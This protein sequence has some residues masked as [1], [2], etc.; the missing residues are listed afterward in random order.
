MTSDYKEAMRSTTI[1]GGLKLITVVISVIKSKV[2]AVLIGPIGFGINS[3]LNSTIDLIR[4]LTGLGIEQSGVKVVAEVKH[5]SYLLSKGVYTVR[6]Y[7]WI[8]GVVGFLS[9]LVFS[10]V[11]SLWSFDSYDYTKTYMIV[12]PAIL[13]LSLYTAELTILRALRSIKKI[14]RTSIL[15]SLMSLL[16]AVPMYYFFE[17]NGI[18]WVV[19]ISSFLSY[20]IILFFAEKSN[21]LKYRSTLLDSWRNGAEL[22]KLGVSMSLGNIIGSMSTFLI[23]IIISN[24]SGVLEVGLYNAG[25]SITNQ[26][27]GL[28]FGAMAADYLPRLSAISGDNSKITEC[29]NNQ[30]EIASLIM[31]P[32]LCV[33]LIGLP[34][35]V[36]ILL[37]AE[38]ASVVSFTRILLFGVFFQSFSWSISYVFIAKGEG[39]LYVRTQ[40]VMSILKLMF[41]FIGYY[42]GQLI[43][44]SVGYLLVQILYLVYVWNISYNKYQFNFTTSLIYFSLKHL[45]LMLLIAMAIYYSKMYHNHEPYLL[46]LAVI[47]GLIS[48]RISLVKLNE[49]ISIKG[50]IKSYISKSN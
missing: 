23:I 32:L 35:V 2:I 20:I 27:V 10:P 42:Y 17:I 15:I 40:L 38:F 47:L 28:I 11:I 7:S 29:I 3:I 9:L 46:V 33:L 36:N 21:V 5:D 34:L 25:W 16:C 22:I 24:L 12:S 19:L 31:A 30:A 39:A 26:Y 45:G 6:F 43:G 50:F 1:F 4:L 41:M 18:A 14:V 13:F 8:T 49:S 37:S 48:I 44:L